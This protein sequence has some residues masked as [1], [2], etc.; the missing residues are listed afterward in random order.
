MRS[1]GESTQLYPMANTQ[2]NIANL[3]LIPYLHL[4]K[5]VKRFMMK[6]IKEDN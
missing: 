2:P 3:P 5:W 6:H 1:G 4:P